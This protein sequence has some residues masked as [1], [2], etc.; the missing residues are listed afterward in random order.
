ML[1]IYTGFRSCIPVLSKTA[2]EY[3]GQFIYK[4]QQ[5]L[6]PAGATSKAI[7]SRGKWFRVERLSGIASLIALVMGLAVV[8]GWSTSFSFFGAHSH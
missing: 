7:Q 6:C 1:A 4:L 5:N 2:L 3:L 8:F